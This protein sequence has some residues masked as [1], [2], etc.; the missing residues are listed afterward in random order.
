MQSGVDLE[1]ENLEAALKGL[2]L[3][4][5]PEEEETKEIASIKMHIDTLRE[6][7]QIVVER[8]VKEVEEKLKEIAIPHYS[9]KKKIDELNAKLAEKKLKWVE[10]ASLSLAEKGQALT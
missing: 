4:T 8:V 2:R 10:R 9:Q 6:H 5:S 1:I 3:E 7:L